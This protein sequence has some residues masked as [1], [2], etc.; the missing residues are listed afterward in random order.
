MEKMYDVWVKNSFRFTGCA[1]EM[2]DNLD[3]MCQDLDAF[4]PFLIETM[5]WHAEEGDDEKM[6]SVK[7]AMQGMC[8]ALRMARSISCMRQSVL[9]DQH[10]GLFESAVRAVDKVVLHMERFM[11][12]V[13]KEL[14][15]L[16]CD[17][18]YR[19][20]LQS[21]LAALQKGVE[22]VSVL[23]AERD[24]VGMAHRRR[25]D[26]NLH[27]RVPSG[28]MVCKD[29]SSCVWMALI[30]LLLL[31][32]PYVPARDEESWCEL[33]DQTCSRFLLSQRWKTVVQS[34]KD[35][36]E[37]QM[38][39][40]CAGRRGRKA[41]LERQMKNNE[42]AMEELLRNYGMD[43]PGTATAHAKAHLCSMLFCRLNGLPASYGLVTLPG[44][45]GSNA[46]CMDNAALLEY[47]TR[48]AKQKML[49]EMV[50]RITVEA[51][52]HRW[53]DNG[54]FAS[55]APL[56][57]IRQAIYRTITRKS[58]NGMPLFRTQTQW[59]AIYKVLEHYGLVNGEKGSL[60]RFAELMAMKWFPKAECPCSYDSMRNLK[61]REIRT[62]PYARWKEE[63]RNLPVA[64]LYLAVAREME[65]QLVSQHV[66][67]EPG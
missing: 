64:R 48:E 9:C 5:R 10:S 55:D 60:K 22:W 36:L 13:E 63:F 7:Y 26:W 15:R 46:C 65:L 45:T 67:D 6:T 30:G 17:D 1:V 23:L 66:I 62:A 14:E 53:P 44:G 37:K 42:K 41:F 8:R 52:L 25:L 49:A 35:T 16:M 28:N 58:D 51:P 19:E 61:C 59:L 56:D 29:L 54:S 33:F 27:F 40:N 34:Y 20:D 18:R 11:A 47:L 39:K 24:V 21:L 50:E 4:L 31:S 3:R 12:D 43:Y 32:L 38:L 57:A 2:V